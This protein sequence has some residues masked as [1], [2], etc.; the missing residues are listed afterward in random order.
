MEDSSMGKR[1]SPLTADEG[2][3]DILGL[4]HVDPRIRSVTV[5]HDGRLARVNQNAKAGSGARVGA[6]IPD[7]EIPETFLVNDLLEEIQYLVV[8][9]RSIYQLVFALKARQ[10]IVATQ[11]GAD[12]TEVA[13]NVVKQLATSATPKNS[14]SSLNE[15]AVQ[16]DNQAPTRKLFRNEDVSRV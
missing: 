16:T 9:G 15:W 11:P 13:Y 3:P 1:S 10:V 5:V 4:V 7:A 14:T 2:E 8:P 12:L 6:A